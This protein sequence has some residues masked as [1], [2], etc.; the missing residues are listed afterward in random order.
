M[1]A[2]SRVWA[3]VDF[4][5][6]GRQAGYLYLPHSVTRSGYGHV[7]TP[8]AVIRNGD[9]PTALLMAGNH[10]DEYEGQVVLG[11]L[12]RELDPARIRGRVIL[13]TQSNAPAAQAGVRVSPIDGGN[14]N[15]AF[16]GD[17]DGTPTFAMAHYYDSVLFP[18][19]DAL[20]DVHSGGISMDYLPFASLCL[21]GDA[22]VDERARA[23][24]A[25]F[26]API[27]IVW[28]A[29]DARMA[30]CAAAR[31]GVAAISG[32]FGGAGTVRQA[33][34]AIVERGIE[35]ALAHLGMLRDGPRRS[36]ASGRNATRWMEIPGNDFYAFANAAG[37]FEPLV[38]LGDTVA[39]GQ[40]C[41]RLHFVD[42]PLREPVTV[43]FRE[44]GLVVCLRQP[45]RVERGD[46]VGHLARDA[47]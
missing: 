31:R 21:S 38:A 6:D 12:A 19:A 44:A 45:A 8:V 24:L 41:G 23:L 46:C 9:G 10:G 5:R 20:I 13:V 36:A 47:A 34:L 7:A 3:D 28:D 29:V 26:D 22:E 4:E 14:L 33:G 15:R 1:A 42:E 35:G 40:P 37:V 2:T 30:E 17:P 16:P 18:M 39:A 11:R 32:E 27:S 25:A 43:P